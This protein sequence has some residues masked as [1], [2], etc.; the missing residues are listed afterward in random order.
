MPDCRA[1]C[2]ASIPSQ[3]RETLHF[4]KVKKEGT[5]FKQISLFWEDN[6]K[7][8]PVS[9]VLIISEGSKIETPIIMQ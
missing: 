8:L 9:A 4:Q 1:G 2:E 6:S 7:L 5:F 3:V